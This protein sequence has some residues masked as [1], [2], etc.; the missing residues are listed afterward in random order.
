M[1]KTIAST[2]EIIDQIGAGG[3]GVVYLAYHIRMQKEV[4]LKADIRDLTTRTEHLRREVDILKQLSNPYIPQVYDFFVED[5]TV[6]TAIEYIDGE[7]LDKALKRGERFTTPQIILW[8]IQI[9]R[10]L[11]YLH[12][13]IHGDPPHGYVHSDIKPANLMRRYNGDIC[14]IDFNVS[15][16]LGE[17]RFVGKSAGY[18]SPEHYGLNFSSYGTGNTGN[19]DT[20]AIQDDTEEYHSDDSTMTMPEMKKDYSKGISPDVRS[21][22][23][24]V[25][26][27]LYHLLSGKRPAK[28]ALDV[29]RLSKDNY[30]EPL[31]N[32]ITKAMNPNPDLRF[33]TA[34]DMLQA[35]LQ[36]R[37]SDKR[38]IRYKKNVVK[39][40]IVTSG[41]MVMGLSLTLIGLRRMQMR[42]SWLK[43]IEYAKEANAE[44][45]QKKALEYLLETV[46]EKRSF[47]YPEQLADSQRE[48]TNILGVYKLYDCYEGKRTVE[49]PSAPFTL[50]LSP[51]ADTVSCLFKDNLSVIDVQSGEVLSTLPAMESALSEIEYI[52]NDTIIFA[53]EAG[54]TA[55]DIKDEE[56]LWR[57]EDG[58]GITIS[59]DS[60]TVAAVYRD[61]EFA[62]IYDAVTGE[63]IQKIDFAG[64]EQ[65]V[66]IND[67]L[68]NPG[69]NLFD[70]NTDGS[71]LAVSFSD[72]S[73]YIIPTEHTAEEPIELANGSEGFY[74]FEGGFFDNYFAY[75]ALGQG[76]FSF[77]VIDMETET[78]LLELESKEYYS[79]TVNEN[80]IYLGQ[81]NKLVQISPETGEQNPLVTT[82]QVIDDYATDGIHTAIVYDDGV[83]FYDT[84]ANLL[85]AADQTISQHLIDLNS[86]VAVMGNSDSPVIRIYEFVEKAKYTFAEYPEFVPHDETRICA[87]GENITLFDINGFSTYTLDGKKVF[88]TVFED[89]EQIYDQQFIREKDSSCLEVTY[90]DGHVD[91]YDAVTGALL[92]GRKSSAIDKSLLEEFETE[93]YRIES[94]LHGTPIVY[95]KSDGRIVTELESEDYLTYITE[96]DDL[97]IAQYLSTKNECYGLLMNQKCEVIGE[98]PYLCDVYNGSLYIDN[99]SGSVRTEKIFTW[100]ELLKKGKE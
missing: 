80:G 19:N 98:V 41:L 60:S 38:S 39:S 99:G 6:Y 84:N 14:L 33:Q 88:E 22:I 58:T 65:S 28:N 18:S 29:V 95:S 30:C 69:D 8:A 26:A 15:V 24:M 20:T 35:F 76:N 73:L 59:A 3:G 47:F 89:S 79:L 67:I 1:R 70:L 34:D 2:Y 10:A 40:I 7:S 87:N 74:H 17:A 86:G 42:E 91:V 11:S 85:N 100:D 78:I 64:H 37:S 36:L 81:T 52:N 43:L 16:A 54:L 90:N 75:G 27:T 9:L 49:L 53:G 56:I 72:G 44:G 12:A 25:G 62:T 77:K 55:F 63:L 97:I 66:A 5:N 50:R 61:E 83:E 31:V 21:D 96:S 4:I 57:G 82:S 68:L 13:P 46:P 93:H 92:E 45:D 23:Y 32:I 48:L 51:N 71:E 94:P